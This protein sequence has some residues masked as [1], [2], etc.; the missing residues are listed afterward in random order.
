[1]IVYVETNFILEIV[2]EQEQVEAT[3]KLL[4]LAEQ[5]DIDIHFPAFSLIEHYWN[6]GFTSF[7]IS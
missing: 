5:G 2:F 3:E 4:M 6:D 1:M 7:W